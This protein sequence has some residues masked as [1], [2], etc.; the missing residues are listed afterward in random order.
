[1]LA[2]ADAC[3]HATRPVR[4]QAGAPVQVSGPVLV[5]AGAWLL[6]MKP[7]RAQ[8]FML[9]T[10]DGQSRC[11]ITYHGD[12]CGP[13]RVLGCMLLRTLLAQTGARLHTTGPVLPRLVLG[14]M[15]GGHFFTYKNLFLCFFNMLT[16]NIVCF[17]SFIDND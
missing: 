14:C 8:G 5:Q 1:M 11:M 12:Q 10:C 16:S 15:Q 4:A 17:V 3:L 6:A 7:V 9:R 2:Q 13:R